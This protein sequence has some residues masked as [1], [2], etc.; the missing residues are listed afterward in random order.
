MSVRSEVIRIFNELVGQAKKISD[1]PTAPSVSGADLLEVSIGG[2]S[3]KGTVSQI[4]SGGSGIVQTIVA[5]T[6]ISVDS[7][8]PANPIVSAT[9]GGGAVSSV[10]GA[11][12]AVIVDL[13]SVLDQG[14]S[15]S[16]A[17][18]VEVIVTG[19]AHTGFFRLHPSQGHEWSYEDT[20]TALAT[21]MALN[22]SGWAVINNL[23]G[24]GITLSTTGVSIANGPLAMGG[25]KITGLAAGTVNGDAV[26]FEQLAGFLSTSLANGS[27]FVG[28]GSGI[29]TAVAMSGE[30]TIINTGAVTLTNSAVI[31]KVL[32]GYTSGAGTVAATDTILQA[33]QKLDGNNGLNWKLTG[34]S[35]LTGTTIIANGGNNLTF[36]G[37]GVFTVASTNTSTSPINFT[38]TYT[39]PAGAAV[40]SYGSTFGGTI[41]G[42]GT[43]NDLICILRVNGALNNSSGTGITHVTFRVDGTH[44]GSVNPS[45]SIAF[46]V[47]A[48]SSITGAE[49]MRGVNSSGV[50]RYQLKADGSTV[51]TTVAT[52]TDFGGSMSTNAA[53]GAG[54]LAMSFQ[55][56]GSATTAHTH[57]GVKATGG[58]TTNAT[59]A[60]YN[61]FW[62]ARSLVVNNTGF[63]GYGFRYAPVV[64][65]TQAGTEVLRA[66]I[67]ESGLSGFQCASNAPTAIVHLGASTTAHASLRIDSGTAPSSPNDGDIWFDGTDIKMRIGGV[68]KT[69]TLV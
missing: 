42:K 53:N 15:A 69:F 47:L 68:T 36:N 11:T 49:I 14:S 16:I 25:G 60:T 44:G 1:L 46:Q 62:D 4:S 13:Q 31:G 17:T 56:S 32:T 52:G 21:T 6:G 5:G 41:T 63:I 57:F 33:I 45:A 35:T 24:V 66:F 38:S 10:N 48:G 29:A 7:T 30:A 54:H 23:L 67:A 40:S 65:G 28:N 58:M 9:G 26:R 22:D 12:G 2:T 37:T 18:E 55:L 3:Y 43:A 50:T 27:I 19:A 8:D 39:V 59:N 34:T 20:G 64:T 51:W 61:S